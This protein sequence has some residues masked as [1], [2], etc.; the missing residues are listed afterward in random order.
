MSLRKQ[1]KILYIHQYFA[2]PMDFLVL[3]LIRMQLHLKM[4]V[5]M[6]LSFAYQTI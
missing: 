1:T 2:L 5:L 3:D 6:L 4:Q